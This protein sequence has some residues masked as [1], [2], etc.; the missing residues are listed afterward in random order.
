MPVRIAQDARID[1]QLSAQRLNDPGGST[2]L[3]S[4]A[5]A[6]SGTSPLSGI[7]DTGPALVTDS[8][9]VVGIGNML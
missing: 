2:L 3:H 8:V 5:E 7:E 4:D 1:L 9:G 6:M